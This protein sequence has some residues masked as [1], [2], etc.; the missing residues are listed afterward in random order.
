MARFLRSYLALWG[1]HHADC[2]VMISG[3]HLGVL[4]NAA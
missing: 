1:Q 2:L 4:P 3:G